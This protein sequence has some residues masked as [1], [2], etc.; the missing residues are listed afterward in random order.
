[1]LEIILVRHGESEMNREG[2]YCGWSNS[3]LTHKGVRQGECVGEKLA[4]ESIDLIISSDLDRCLM[5]AEIINRFHRKNIIKET[6]FK[7]LNF[8]L[9]E[10]LNYNKICSD[11]P[12]EAK[13]WQDDYIN[14]KIPGGESLSDMHRRVNNGFNKIINKHKKG[15]ILIVTHSGVIRS[16]LAEQICKTIEATWRF[17]IDNCGITRLHFIDDFS[18]IIGMNQ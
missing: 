14:F 16:I 2:V 7:E 13:L 9:W 6:A 11:F 10:G 8:G 12:K 1:M 15:K 3:P 5:T 4:N 18:V 17:K